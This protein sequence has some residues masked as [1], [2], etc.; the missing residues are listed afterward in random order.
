MEQRVLNTRSVK[1]VSENGIESWTTVV[2]DSLHYESHLI[3]TNCG[4]LGIRGDAEPSTN[5]AALSDRAWAHIVHSAEDDDETGDVEFDL[6]RC[7][8]DTKQQINRYR[9][10]ACLVAY[11]LIF[12]KHIPSCRPNL[13]YANMLC[14]KW[15]DILDREYNV[16]KPSKRKKEKMQMLIELFATESAV[17][18]KFLLRESGVDFEDMHPDENGHLSPFAVEQ[19]TDVVCSLQRCCDWEVIHNAWSHSLDHSPATS[20]HR[21]QVMS[22]MAGVHGSVPDRVSMTGVPSEPKAPEAQPQRRA[23]EP[24]PDQDYGYDAAAIDDSERDHAAANQQQQQQLPQFP[25]RDDDVFSTTDS[26]VVAA[27]E[28]TERAYRGEAS[29]S[30]AA[31]LEMANRAR[32]GGAAQAP[33][34]QQ[35]QVRPL[36]AA[37]QADWENRHN[38]RLEAARATNGQSAGTPVLITRFMRNGLS[39]EEAAEGAKVLAERREIR[40]EMSRR[41]LAKTIRA[42]GESQKKQVAKLLTDKRDAETKEPQMRLP[43]TGDFINAERAAAACL[44]DTQE[45]M[46]SGYEEQFVRDVVDCKPTQTFGNDHVLVGHANKPK[47]EYKVRPTEGMN[48]PADYDFNWVRLR[49]F[50]KSEGL[51]ATGGQKNKSPYVSTAAEVKKE[52]SEGKYSLINTKSMTKESIRD[53]IYQMGQRTSDNKMRIPRHASTEARQM[54]N[55]QSCMLSGDQDIKDAA[56]PPSFVHPHCM[57]DA[58]FQKARRY[59]KRLDYLVDKRALPSCILPESFEKGVPIIEC[60]NGNGVY[61]NKY[62]ASEHAALKVES[63]QY[64]STVPGIA[65]GEFKEGPASFQADQGSD[66]REQEDPVHDEVRKEVEAKRKAGPDVDL[67]DAPQGKRAKDSAAAEPMDVEEASDADFAEASGSEAGDPPEPRAGASPSDLSSVRLGVEVPG[68]V[69]GDDVRPGAGACDRAASASVAPSLKHRSLPD[70]WDQGAIYYSLK[71]AETLYNDCEA[72]VDAVRAKFP[73]VYQEER[74]ETFEKL[75][76]ITLRFPGVTD[77]KAA[78]EEDVGASVNAKAKLILPLSCAVPRKQSRYCDVG[79]QVQSARASTA[80]TEAVHS[81]AHG[82]AVRAD[83]P[84]VLEYEAET[85][86]VNSGFVMEG[87]LFARSTWQRF[88]LSALD[89]RGMRTPEEEKRVLDQGLCMSHRVRNHMAASGEKV[90]GVD[91][92]GSTLATEVTWGAMERNKRKRADTVTGGAA[93]GT[94]SFSAQSRKREDEVNR[95]VMEDALNVDNQ[96]EV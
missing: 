47:W 62:I 84:E 6:Q 94:E 82:R 56:K 43:S 49:A 86:G 15:Y 10:C 69:D 16:P 73:D 22:E 45:V 11:V 57:Y 60:E 63:A 19:L 48:K 13:T 34:Q 85:R 80:L 75:P 23:P 64:L 55:Q 28:A 24:E 18:E 81:L 29:T 91:F 58:D 21:F 46:S 88:T 39:R 5:R 92:C 8:D 54:R 25:E 32:D 68:S 27:A 79:N 53:T 38:E 52:S 36:T 77:L 51:E 59:D 42:D 14:N 95:E 87:N 12:I 70:L 40:A 71:M 31:V 78:S 17:F 3:C 90:R 1:T 65:G 96:F 50:G 4:P 89:A 61:F 41:A 67:Q 74:E 26:A 66:Y 2:L 30:A 33:Q 83:D 72:Y 37:Q 7:S 20:S 44:P 9:V 93:G 35:Q 76:H